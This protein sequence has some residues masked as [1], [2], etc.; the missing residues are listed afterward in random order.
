MGVFLQDPGS[1]NQDR[2]ILSMADFPWATPKKPLDP[3][4]ALILGGKTPAKTIPFLE[5]SVQRGLFDI[6]ILGGTLGFTFLKALGFETGRSMVASLYLSRCKEILN[7]AYATGV[8]VVLPVDHIASMKI[9]PNVT[10]KMV[11]RDEQ[12]PDDMMGLDI[13]MDTI[14][15]FSRYLKRARFICWHGPLGASEIANFS[16]GTLEIA[17]S[18][19]RSSASVAVCGESLLSSL[20]KSGYI[21]RMDHVA[22]NLEDMRDF[23]EK[24]MIGYE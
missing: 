21:D 7:I 8:Q 18:L 10:I 12:I 13:G 23:I 2:R 11:R 3:R 19:A 15:L 14:R 16:G 9:E 6:I 17:R 24:R 5:K 22:E 1:G 20:R 4:A